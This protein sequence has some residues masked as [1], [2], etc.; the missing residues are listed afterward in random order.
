MIIVTVF[1]LDLCR[2]QPLP[3]PHNVPRKRHCR[4]CP[5]ARPH[6]AEECCQPRYSGP[7]WPPR[8]E[9]CSPR[10][11][12]RPR[13]RWVQARCRESRSTPGGE[14]CCPSP[15]GP[16]YWG[17]RRALQGSSWGWRC[18]GCTEAEWGS[19]WG[20]DQPEWGR[21][22]LQCYQCYLIYVPSKLLMR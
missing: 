19:S 1:I 22:R 7:C 3:P 9:E 10:T 13:S 14:L 8:A 18:P 16:G 20:W 11:L 12:P 17:S 5:Q 15:P 6:C 4:G 2:S 21:E